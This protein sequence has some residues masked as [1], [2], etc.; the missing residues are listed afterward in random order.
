M[1]KRRNERGRRKVTGLSTVRSELQARGPLPATVAAATEGVVEEEEAPVPTWEFLGARG[2][3]CGGRAA[4]EE[5]EGILG[6]LEALHEPVA[7]ESLAFELLFYLYLVAHLFLQN[8]NVY[9]ANTCNYNVSLLLL[10]MMTLCKRIMLKYLSSTGG[11]ALQVSKGAHTV[12]TLLLIAAVTANSVFFI[13]QLFLGHPLVNFLCL[14]YPSLLSV[15]I[16]GVSGGQERTGNGRAV[17]RRIF[18]LL[19]SAIE[20][21]YYVGVLPLRFLQHDYLYYD[22][23]RCVL[24]VA[25]V[26]INSL[27]MLLAH[28][29]HTSFVDLYLQA[30]TLGRWE[31]Y[32]PE[33][34]ERRKESV[35]EWSAKHGPYCRGEVVTYKGGF[36]VAR[37]AQNT[38]EPGRLLLPLLLFALFSKPDRT[39][40]I[41]IGVQGVVVAAQMGLLVASNHWGVYG[42]MLAF[43]YAVMFYCVY[44]RRKNMLLFRQYQFDEWGGILPMQW[45]KKGQYA[46]LLRQRLPMESPRCMQPQD[47]Q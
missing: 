30:Q 41:L 1:V 33:G 8:Y 38:M 7:Q 45:P 28:M 10:T 21:A 36:F 25:F 44:T 34:T 29:L 12:L 24:L 14:F 37:N 40:L 27:V 31:P 18:K 22:L 3:P 17:M 43:S 13:V 4:R 11:V 47:M 2:V 26:F 46:A 39:H 23:G 42:V 9:K 35:Q 15:F 19:Y 16:F 6:R 32:R 5:V 20:Y